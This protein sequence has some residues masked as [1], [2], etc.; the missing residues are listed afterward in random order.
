MSFPVT[1]L[2]DLVPP[3]QHLLTEDRV[4]LEASGVPLGG[5]G[6]LDVP[7]AEPELADGA[8]VLSAGAVFSLEESP[9]DPKRTKE[10]RG[11]LF[12]MIFRDEAACD[13]DSKHLFEN[14]VLP[15]HDKP[16]ENNKDNEERNFK[17]EVA[18]KEAFHTQQKRHSVPECMQADGARV[19]EHRHQD[20]DEGIM[21]FA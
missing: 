18:E 10:R 1:I 5:G 16:A 17:E 20:F 7:V 3:A 6:S 11:R 21:R 12:H 13:V 9:G 4:L 2:V 19:T 8:T 14:A 15:P